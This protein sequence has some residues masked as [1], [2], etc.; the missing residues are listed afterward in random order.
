MKATENLLIALVCFGIILYHYIYNFSIISH[1]YMF[2]LLMILFGVGGWNFG[3]G[4]AKLYK[5]SR[6]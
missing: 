5:D 1:P 6:K 4:V 2:L 3:V